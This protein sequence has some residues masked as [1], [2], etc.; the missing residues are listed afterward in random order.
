MRYLVFASLLSLVVAPAAAAGSSPLLG[1]WRVFELNGAP[2][3]AGSEVTIRFEPDGKVS[4]K[5]SCNR[6]GSSYRVEEDRLSLSPAMATRMACA[7]PLMA[8]EALFF[9]LIEKAAEWTEVQ[10]RLTI[11]TAEGSTIRASRVK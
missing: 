10:G 4:G 8:Q 1:E 2:L 9:S 5:G 6:Y 7:P 3:A 11:T